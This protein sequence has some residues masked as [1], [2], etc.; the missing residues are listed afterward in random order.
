[1]TIFCLFQFWLNALLQEFLMIPYPRQKLCKIPFWLKHKPRKSNA[2]PMKLLVIYAHGLSKSVP[3]SMYYKNN[4][5]TTDGLDDTYHPLS[6]KK[7][8]HYVL[9]IIIIRLHCSTTYVDVAYCYQP[10]S[11]WSVGLSITLVIPAKTAEPIE[12]PFGIP[13]WAQGMM[14]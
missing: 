1:M 8:T 12:M 2:K 5:L 13:W 4:G 3:H 10:S 11:V 14:Y 6:W 9:Q 7:I